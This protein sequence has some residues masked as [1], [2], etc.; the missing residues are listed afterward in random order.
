MNKDRIW[1]LASKKLAGEA[2]GEE[3][4]ELEGLLRSDPDM[5]YALQNITDIWKLQPRSTVEAEEVFLRHIKRM[6][7]SGIEWQK[8]KTEEHDMNLA[9]EYPF[10]ARPRSRKKLLFG[11]AAITALV[12]TGIL[13]LYQKDQRAS[14]TRILSSTNHTTE[15]NE[16][17]TRN[18]SKSKI[19]LPDGTQ[20]WL[21]AGSNLIYNKEFGNNGL[22]EVELS[23][24]A[25][26]DVVRNEEQPFIIHTRQV[27]VRVLGT[28]FNVK[29]YPGEKRTE[30]TLIRG[31]VQVLIKNRPDETITLKPNEK[32]V[33]V[34]DEI[35]EYV[36]EPKTAVKKEPIV[37]LGK[38]NYYPNNESLV[39][40]TAWVDNNLVFDNES[41]LEVAA[42]M[43]R[44]YNVQF[45]FNGDQLKELRLTGVFTSETIQQALEALSITAGFNFTIEGNKITVSDKKR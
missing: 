28:A 25:F 29:S 15:K 24:E 20:V 14:P 41:F 12:I 37:S 32:L 9:G 45:K 19:T 7:A 36:T 6:K 35:E 34:N 44:W 3:L 33:V 40:E 18:G 5:H 2:S 38:L 27:D 23:G 31:K 16:I 8:T 13:L 1:H 30:T 4:A 39:V 11:I 42:K 43:E 21:N 17:S 22:R 10:P 26:F